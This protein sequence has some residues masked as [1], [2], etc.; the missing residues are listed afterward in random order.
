MIDTLNYEPFFF[1]CCIGLGLHG[2]YISRILA[3]Q[4]L[5]WLDVMSAV[6]FS[7]AFYFAY[8]CLSK[9]KGGCDGRRRKI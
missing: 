1:F 6:F 4:Y 2:F 8:F 9:L 5:F 7:L 3:P